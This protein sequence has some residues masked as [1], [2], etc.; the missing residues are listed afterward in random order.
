[1]TCDPSTLLVQLT[2]GDLKSNI[3]EATNETISGIKPALIKEIRGKIKDF[4]KDDGFVYGLSGISRFMGC[5]KATAWNYK[6]R[7]L[8]NEAIVQYSS[9]NIVADKAKL[10]EIMRRMEA[11]RGKE[12]DNDQNNQKS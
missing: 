1:M 2:I 12:L 6:E 10:I 9:H 5:C 7:G 11:E 8:L 4:S 3:R